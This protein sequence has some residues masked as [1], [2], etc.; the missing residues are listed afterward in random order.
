MRTFQGV[1]QF[2][3]GTGEGDAVTNQMFDLQRHL[4]ALGHPSKILAQHIGPGLSGRITPASTYQGSPDELLL[5][6]HSHG[7]DLLD[8][9]VDLPNPIVAVYHNV[10][11][12]QYFS[13]PFTRRYIRLGRHQLEVLARRSLFGV[14][15]SNFNR[16]EMLAAGF[17]RVEVLPVRTDFSAFAPAVAGGG[18]RTG[19]WLYVGRVVGNKCQHRLVRAFAAYHH[20]FDPSAR[21]VLIGGVADEDYLEQVE[22]EARR[23]RVL[24]HLVFMGKVSDRELC[25]AYSRAGVFV[26]LSEHEGFGVPLIEAMAAGVPVVAY[27]AAAIPETLGGAGILL[28]TQEPD[29]VAATV[30]AVLADRPLVDRL[31]RRQFVRVEQVE[32]FDVRRELARIVRRAEGHRLPLEIQVQGPFETSYSLAAINRRLALALD[33]H[34]DVAASIYATEGPG[35]YEPAPEDLARHPAATRLF[36]R[37]RDVP[38]PDVVIRQM[39]PPRVIDSPGALTLEYFGWEE[40]GLPPSMVSE[41]NAYLDGVGVMSNYV[42]DVLRDAGV[43]VPIHVVANGVDPPDPTS[44]VD[45]PEL[46]D[47]RPF[48]F[49]HISSAFP[50]KGIDVLLR[51]YFDAFDGSSAVSLVLKTFPNIHNQVGPLLSE[52]RAA[53]ANP[54]DVRWIDRDFEDREIEAL[55]GLADC[56]VH[57]ARGEGFGLPVAEAMLADVPVIATAHGGLA[58]F[59]SEDTAITVP[60]V[61]APAESHFGLEDSWWAEPDAGALARS[62]VE[63]A[64]APDASEVRARIEAARELVSREYTWEMAALRW[65]RLIAEV[66]DGASRPRVAMVTSWNARCGIAENSR[67][68]IEHLRDVVDVDVFADVDVEVIDPQAERGVVRTWKNRWE[69]ELDTLEEALLGSDADVVHVQMNFG[70]FEFE[71]LAAVLERQRARRGVVVTLHRTLDYDD[72]GNLLTLRDIRST[73]RRADR[74]IVHQESDVRYLEEMGID[75]NVTLIPLGASPAPDVSAE[76]ARATLGLGRRPVLATFGF[77]LPHKGTMDLVAA[78]GELRRSRPDVLLLAL[79]A[80]YPAVDSREYEARLRAQI[81]E[82]GLERNVVLVTEYLPDDT[83]RTLLRAADAIVLPY[84]ET[85]ESSSAALRFVLPVGRATVVSDEPLFRDAGDAVH[86]V[87]GGSPSDLASAIARVLDD[88]RYREDLAARAARR[89]RQF[90][91]DRVAAEHRQVYAAAAGAGRARRAAAAPSSGGA[92]SSGRR[93]SSGPPDAPDWSGS[94]ARSGRPATGGGTG[95]VTGP[96]LVGTSG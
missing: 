90:L 96:S 7:H 67:Y 53:H 88:D 6:H 92:A 45:A 26:S 66:E 57:P 71:H 49:L 80:A 16:R 14:A 13:H 78:V 83:A 84:R 4:H 48:V 56:Y 43:T 77:L 68:L 55:Y 63:L 86:V 41:F 75:D 33:D 22:D 27:G 64:G 24:D 29:V 47:L 54:P 39:W 28:R 3:S 82:L 61:L 20:N 94:P 60:F 70:F 44:T 5:V 18:P 58:D 85:G 21:L 37:S 31:V 9:L 10:T 32:S 35:D 11:P 50:R 36:E 87:R 79:C 23:L 91:W 1:H 12:E 73:L 65:R 51:A 46:E 30:H 40:S 95:L 59:V 42:R 19:D 25:A 8:D 15:V 17:R 62:M 89:A 74:L 81:D 2:H 34:R 93:G 76:E 38:F 52:L 69:P 72:R